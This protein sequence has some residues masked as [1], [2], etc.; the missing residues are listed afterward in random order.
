MRGQDGA[1]LHVGHIAAF[2]LMKAHQDRAFLGHIAHGQSG[3]EAVAP[4]RA[5][6]GAQHGFGLDFAQV[7][8]VVFQHTLFDRDLRHAIQMLHLAAAAGAWVQAKIRATRSH[9]LG[10]LFQQ[11]LQTALLPLVLFAV[12]IDGHHFKRQSAFDEHHFAVGTVRHAL[13]VQIE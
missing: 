7:P 11:G 8:Q 13:G 9:T 6:D 12:H 5:L 3:A 4:V 1:H 10:R 2:A